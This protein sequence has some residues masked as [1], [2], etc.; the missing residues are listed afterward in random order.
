MVVENLIQ[1]KK[2]TQLLKIPQEKNKNK[3]FII[4]NPENPTYQSP[5]SRQ[6]EDEKL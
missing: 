4:G 1:H 2:K 6:H 5:H 3:K